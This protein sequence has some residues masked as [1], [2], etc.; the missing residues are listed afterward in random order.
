MFLTMNNIHTI[1]QL[2]FIMRKN[3]MEGMLVHKKITY[4]LKHIF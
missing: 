3:S 2:I 1:P 4:S